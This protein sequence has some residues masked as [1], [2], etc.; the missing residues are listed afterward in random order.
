MNRRWL[1]GLL[2]A[3]ADVRRRLGLVGSDG[4]GVRG[5]L[6][7]TLRDPALW[8]PTRRSV[9]GGV[10]TGLFVGWM[11][12]PLQMLVAAVLASA[13][14]VHVPVSV[15][16]VWFTNPL[17][18]GPLLYAAWRTGS[19]LL[20]T[21]ARAVP[22]DGGLGALLANLGDAWPAVLAGCLFWGAV[23][24]VVGFFATR[25]LWR[26]AAVRRWRN[27][28]TATPPVSGHP[29]RRRTDPPRP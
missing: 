14:R 17:T 10:A 20:G 5:W 9:A 12:V 11:P 19:N 28:R 13:L 16:M 4:R 8:A 2:P 29:H 7:T 18:A 26:I 24:A 3:P 15:V 25:L 22:P 21:P 27:R 23:S 1:T 6:A